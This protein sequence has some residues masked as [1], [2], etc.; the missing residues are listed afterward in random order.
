MLKEFREFIARGNVLDLA[1]G[2]IIGAGFQKI[3]DS[4]VKDILLAGLGA[5]TP[6]SLD[7][8]T[9]WVIHIGSAKVGIGNFINSVIQFLILAFAVFLIVK[10]ANKM[11]RLMEEQAKEDTAVEV[12]P[13][14]KE[15][16]QTK[17][18]VQQE[19]MI[20]LLEQIAAA[21]RR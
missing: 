17:L 2:V 1:V 21:P 11:R 18:I 4:L 10:A 14:A 7:D 6:K 12:L 8:V 13:E 19:R 16:P 9:K 3:V 20:E 5:V 15:D